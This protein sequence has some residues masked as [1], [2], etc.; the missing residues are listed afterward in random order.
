[1]FHKI[2]YAPLLLI[3]FVFAIF[4]ACDRDRC[5]NVICDGPESYCLDGQCIC[6]PGYEGPDCDIL[7]KD[8]YVGNY[9]VTES[10]NPGVERGWTFT[11]ILS[12]NGVDK[13][14]FTNVLNTG[15]SAEA[16]I[17]TNSAI[18]FDTQNLGSI[19]FAGVGNYIENANR[20]ELEYEYYVNGQANRCTAFLYR[21]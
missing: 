13:I 18:R 10:C 11:T 2:K 5:A 21:Q 9:R 3:S 12:G 17:V 6:P 14:E 15:L 16:V 20:I 7:S 1:M 4:S 19:Q 8:K